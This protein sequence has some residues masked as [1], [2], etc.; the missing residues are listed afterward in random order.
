MNRKLFTAVGLVGAMGVALTGPSVAAWTPFSIGASHTEADAISANQAVA[1]V[2][3][4]TNLQGTVS[5]IFTNRGVAT[6]VDVGGHYPDLTFRAVLFPDAP[7]STGRFPSSERRIVIVSGT[8]KLFHGQPE[9]F[10]T[11]RNQIAL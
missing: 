6:I 5:E 8:I 11:S 4:W 7:S 2:S 10:V 9:I 1:H 3:E